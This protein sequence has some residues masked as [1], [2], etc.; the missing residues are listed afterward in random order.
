M[1]DHDPYDGNYGS[2]APAEAKGKDDAPESE[3]IELKKDRLQVKR[4]EREEAAKAAAS[5]KPARKTSSSG[6]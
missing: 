4:A 5:E 6:P 3:A 1:S 2:A